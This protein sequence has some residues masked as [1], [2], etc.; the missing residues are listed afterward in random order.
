MLAQPNLNYN[1][2]NYFI[3]GEMRNCKFILDNH[4]TENLNSFDIIIE[5]ESPIISFRNHD[6]TWVAISQDR[7]ANDFSPKAIRLQ[8]GMYVQANCNWGIWELNAKNTKQ[9]LWR[10]NPDFA[11]PITQ[12]S[13]ENNIKKIVSATPDFNFSDNL[14]L[15]ISDKGIVEISRSPIPFS[16]IAC[17]TDHCDF[18]TAENLKFQRAFFKE[19]GIKITKG[20]FLNHFSKREENASFE[21][22]K[23][24][25]EKW[26][27]DGHELAY[28]SLTQSIR[29]Q[30]VAI[31][32][33][34]DF[35]PPFS[36][37]PVWIDHGFQPYN[38]SLFQN[39]GIPKEK[40][41]ALLEE[42]NI[43]ILWNYID[44][45]TSTNGVINQLDYSQFNLI[46]YYNSLS[47]FSFSKRITSIVKAIIFHYDNNENR[48]RNYIE[49][50]SCLKSISNKKDF[51]VIV[52]LIKNLL[53]LSLL[54][55]RVVLKWNS[56]K[57]ATFKAAK[58]SPV[59]F[60]HK[61]KNKNFTI[62]QTIEMVDFN[63]ALAPKN[64]DNLIDASGLFIAHTYFS[65]NSK[66][67]S[68]SLF[69][70]DAKSNLIAASNF[71]YLSQKIHNDSIWNPTLSQL[72]AYY[73]SFQNTLFDMDANGIIFIKNNNNIPS[74]SAI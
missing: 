32:E 50:V 73:N 58:F 69:N 62:F 8:N 64:I 54:L 18:D 74:R 22:D 61:I 13:N 36:K 72:L 41:E 10:F 43:S 26:I 4:T 24:E 56:V 51:S 11:A 45:G 15:L 6:Y 23:Q 63:L 47:E 34:T 28:H 48:I 33:F 55:L 66:K 29:N 65:V 3:S 71:S 59:F 37:I 44:S 9:L 40:Y 30:S 57:K 14:E 42:K 49:V 53:P 35:K 67:Y 20:F 60:K 12:Y 16:A 19:K 70:S 7:I 1:S 2:F 39:N 17:F 21:R 46:S 27:A 52:K 25:L 38:F 5:F 31:T 68:G